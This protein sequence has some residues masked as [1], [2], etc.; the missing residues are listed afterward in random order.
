MLMVDAATKKRL[1]FEQS[2]LYSLIIDFISILYSPESKSDR[3]V[4]VNSLLISAAVLLYAERFVE[5][6]IDLQSQLPTRKYTNA[7]ILDLHVLVAIQLSPMF[8]ET[9]N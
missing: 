6:L 5:F 7:L 4:C 2:W 3:M 1:R 8:K 9:R